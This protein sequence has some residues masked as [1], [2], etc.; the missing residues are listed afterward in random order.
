MSHP[1]LQTRSN[2]VNAAPSSACSSVGSLHNSV[3]ILWRHLS[4]VWCMAKHSLT[5][6]LQHYQRQY[7]FL[8][9]LTR[10]IWMFMSI[11]ICRQFSVPMGS[12]HM[13]CM[14]LYGA[15][16]M[17]LNNFWALFAQWPRASMQKSLVSASLVNNKTKIYMIVARKKEFDWYCKL[18]VNDN[19]NTSLCFPSTFHSILILLSIDL[20]PWA[21]A[22]LPSMNFASN[23]L[24]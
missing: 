9:W 4:S 14:I 19:D 17:F 18:L 10:I 2:G 21:S 3:L 8:I 1:R 13:K 22:A 7:V 12:R 11:L 23:W 15:T 6:M 16:S 5:H 20:T 24:Y